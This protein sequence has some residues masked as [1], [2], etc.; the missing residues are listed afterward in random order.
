MSERSLAEEESSGEEHDELGTQFDLPSEE[1]GGASKKMKA[2]L[3]EGQKFPTVKD[4]RN[5]VVQHAVQNYYEF[6]VVKSDNKRYTIKCNDVMCMWHLH[7][8]HVSGGPVF[9]VKGIDEHTCGGL[10]KLLNGQV[11]NAWVA[12]IIEPKLRDT[13]DYKPVEIMNDLFRDHGVKVKYRCAWKGK[14]IAK[15]SILG[16]DDNGY[17]Y[18]RLYCEEVQRSNLGSRVVGANTLTRVSALGFASDRE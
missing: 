15:A 9:V 14:E 16:S 6:V 13:P 18:S 5:A 17:R 4:L 1:D 2:S 7:G 11:T 8:S 12:W 3:Y 10:A